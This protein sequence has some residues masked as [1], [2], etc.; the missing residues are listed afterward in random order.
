VR[1]TQEIEKAEAVKKEL[2]FQQEKQEQ[3][4]RQEHQL[5]EQQLKFQKAIEA[6]RLQSEAKASSTKLPK[7]SIAKFDGKYENWLPFWNKFKAEIDSTDLSPVTKFAYLKELVEPKIRMDI[8]GLPLTTEGYSRAKAILSGE[9]GKTS[10]I[11][12]ALPGIKSNIVR[13]H[14]GWQDWGA[15]AQLVKETKVWRDISSCN[16]ETGKEKGKRKDRQH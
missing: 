13:G 6:D 3:K 14:E 9:Y 2:M 10:E 4:L 7:L 15:L 1:K 5:F 8:D 16:E 11:V 12:N